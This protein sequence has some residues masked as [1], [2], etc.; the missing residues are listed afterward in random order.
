[1]GRHEYGEQFDRRAKDEAAERAKALK[2][3]AAI[4]NEKSAQH[5]LMLGLEEW[6]ADKNAIDAIRTIISEL[7]E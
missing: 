5:D 3:I 7:P 6:Q 4:C 1:M 2:L